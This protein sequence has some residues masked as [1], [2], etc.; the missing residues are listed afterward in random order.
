MSGI[1]W[2]RKIQTGRILRC[3][4]GWWSG[5]NH[6]RLLLRLHDTPVIL[7]RSTTL[8]MQTVYEEQITRL[9][10]ISIG[11]RGSADIIYGRN[12]KHRYWSEDNFAPRRL[13][14]DVIFMISRNEQTPRAAAGTKQKYTPRQR[15]DFSLEAD[16]LFPRLVIPDFGL[17]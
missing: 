13:V 9:C 1:L 12:S 3:I 10:E 14:S 17:K 16:V 11:L 4:S 15:W 5:H 6:L 2:S 8:H 7:E